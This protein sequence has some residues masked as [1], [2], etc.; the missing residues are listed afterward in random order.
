MATAISIF[1]SLP[2]HGRK[3]CALSG[4]ECRTSSLKPQD[5]GVFGVFQL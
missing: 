3:K 1:S 5:K 4:V 2:N